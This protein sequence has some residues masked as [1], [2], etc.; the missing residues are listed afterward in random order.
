MAKPAGS[1]TLRINFYYF[2]LAAGGGCWW[3]RL[4]PSKRLNIP[5][6]TRFILSPRGGNGDRY[7]D[8]GTTA[9]RRR[10]LV[11]LLAI[12]ELYPGCLR[13]RAAGDAAR[14]G[15]IWESGRTGEYAAKRTGDER[16]AKRRGELQRIFDPDAEAARAELFYP[17]D[18]W[19]AASFLILDSKLIKFFVSGNKLDTLSGA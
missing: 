9:H 7:V 1:R 10:Q 2:L 18:S 14:S 6:G 11:P 8:Q 17:S 5:W 4:L 12:R 19:G 16:R 15:C 3:R 13:R